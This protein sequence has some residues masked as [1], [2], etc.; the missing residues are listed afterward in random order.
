MHP[1]EK[2]DTTPGIHNVLSI[3]DEVNVVFPENA[4]TATNT[5]TLKCQINGKFCNTLID[6]GASC[7]I[8][9][10]FSY[11]VSFDYE[12]NRVKLGLQWC[13]GLR[14]QRMEFV[15]LAEE[16]FMPARSEKFVAVK[17]RTQNSL[18]LGDFEPTRFGLNT[19]QLYVNRARVMPNTCGV[20]LITFLN[21]S[22]KE[23]TLPSWKVVGSWQQ[24]GES[25]SYIRTP[26]KSRIRMEVIPMGDNLNPDQRFQVFELINEFQILFPDNSMK[27]KR[28]NVMKH[29][30][31]TNDVL[32]QFRKPFRIPHAFEEEVNKLVNEMFEND[33]ISPS[34]SP[35]NAPVMLVKKKDQ[36]MSFVCD[37][38]AFNDVTE[39]DTSPLPLIKNVVDKMGG[40]GQ[41]FGPNLTRHLRIGPCHSKSK[42]RK[43]SFFSSQRKI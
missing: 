6:S 18:V 34:T 29:K 37:F 7:C 28:V 39:K 27:P 31:V 21:T 13:T 26:E 16:T 43:H 14:I 12:N 25:V 32:P 38:R 15:R 30:I 3:Y 11:Q 19:N 22:G 35:W 17:C 20:F 40:G 33:I 36:G 5:V 4:S 42:I 1:A 2:K 9:D 23:F 10:K 8:I 24:L 41:C